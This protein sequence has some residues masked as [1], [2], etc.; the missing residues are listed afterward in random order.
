MS[1]P[2]ARGAPPTA[3]EASAGLGVIWAGLSPREQKTRDEAY[4]KA[5]AYILRCC[6]KRRGRS[7][8]SQIPECQP[9]AK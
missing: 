9:E 3:H 5:Q 7:R 2:W 4:A 8:E 6:A 1:W